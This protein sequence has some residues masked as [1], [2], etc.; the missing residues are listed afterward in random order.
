MDWLSS[1]VLKE[2]LV[3]TDDLGVLLQSD[4]DAI[5]QVDDALHAVCGQERVAEDLFRHLPDT[6]DAS[7]PLD[8]PDDCP[9]QVVVHDD[10][11]IL[12]VLAFA[13]HVGRDKDPEFLIGSHTPLVAHGAEPPGHL[14]WVNGASRDP[15]HSTHAPLLQFLSQIEDCV[16]ELGE[17][18][19][20]RLGECIGKQLVGGL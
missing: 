19:Y 5:A 4:P 11:A 15:G 12:Q 14:S 20:F 10:R 6:V 7:R 16:G 2:R 8:E 9:W 1:F 18:Q 13:Q 17:D 3:C